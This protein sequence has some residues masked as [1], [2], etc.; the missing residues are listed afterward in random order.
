MWRVGP[1]P[2]HTKFAE[3]NAEPVLPQV[4]ASA[5]L[6]GESQCFTKSDALKPPAYIPELKV[7]HQLPLSTQRPHDALVGIS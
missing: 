7:P 4:C 5:G 1:R 6:A 2:Q 3:L